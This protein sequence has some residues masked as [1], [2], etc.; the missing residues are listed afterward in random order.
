[1]KN[2]PP[3]YSPRLQPIALLMTFAVCALPYAV[4]WLVW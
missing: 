2:D 1:M 3:E 4:A